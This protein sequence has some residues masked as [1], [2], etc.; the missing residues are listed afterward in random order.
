MNVNLQ[1][2]TRSTSFQIPDFGQTIN[3]SNYLPESITREEPI[4]TTDYETG[5]KTVTPGEFKRMNDKPTQ[6]TTLID[7]NGDRVL[8]LS[9]FSDPNIPPVFI[10]VSQNT[11]FVN[12]LNTLFNKAYGAGNVSVEKLFEQHAKSLL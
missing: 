2:N 7:N 5:E 4:V 3:L 10:N 9:G 12:Q 11:P 8:M 1:E 6:V